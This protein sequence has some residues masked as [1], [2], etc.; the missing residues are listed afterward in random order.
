MFSKAILIASLMASPAAF[1]GNYPLLNDYD[2]VAK[3]ALALARTANTVD[4]VQSLLEMQR[5]L[6]TMGGDIMKLY[7]SKNPICQP[8]FDVYLTEIATSESKTLKE[9]HE[10][11][12]DGKGLPAA[13]K[14]C[15]LG[16]SQVVHPS[17]NVRRILDGWNETSRA[18][19]LDETDEV[20]RHNVKIERNLDNPPN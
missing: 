8:Q 16:R 17:M 2:A 1:A 12:H 20:I 10:R 15:Y 18:D 7:A 11:Y 13:P 14:H 4:E 9:L 3:E 6:V 5:K 19:V